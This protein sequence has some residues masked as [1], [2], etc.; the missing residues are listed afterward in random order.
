MNT[1]FLISA[2]DNAILEVRRT[3]TLLEGYNTKEDSAING[4]PYLVEV[5]VTDPA[6]DPATEVKEGPT[7]AYDGINATRIYA[8][9]AKTAQELN[10]EQLNNDINVL[11]AAGKDTV[12]VLVE[13]IDYLL[14]NTAMS[15]TDFTPNVRQAYQDLKVIAD[16]IKANS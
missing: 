3:Q 9:R 12:L 10:T 14:A 7:D 11:R 4:K 6:Y 8:V 15:G 1:Y 16:R 5:A 2:T 13:L